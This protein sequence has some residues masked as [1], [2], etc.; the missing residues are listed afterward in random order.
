MSRRAL[1]LVALG[2]L[3]PWLLAGCSSLPLFGKKSGE[4]AAAPPAPPAYQLQVDAPGE[5]RQL[6]LTYLDLG[7]FQ[8]APETKT[9]TEVE[10]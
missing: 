1:R 7:G 10:L 6:L 3:F 4:E 5:L 9:I 2:A 8:S